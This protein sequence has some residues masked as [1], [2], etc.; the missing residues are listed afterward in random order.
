METLFKEHLVKIEK[1]EKTLL[2]NPYSL[3]CI[4][5][6]NEDGIQKEAI[7]KIDPSR[8]RWYAMAYRNCDLDDLREVNVFC[9]TLNVMKKELKPKINTDAI[10]TD[11]S[12]EKVIG[13]PLF[14]KSINQLN[15]TRGR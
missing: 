1:V 5:I 9:R 12:K 14:Y 8:K 6:K 11:I 10:M 7:L 4:A 15:Q 3:R 2:D 13:N